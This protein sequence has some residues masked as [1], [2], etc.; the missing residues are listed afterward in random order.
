MQ[1]PIQPTKNEK[2]DI[3][4]NLLKQIQDLWP[5]PRSICGP[6][7]RKSIEYFAS[8]HDQIQVCE[9]KTGT[10]LGGGWIVPDEWSL[11]HCFIKDENENIL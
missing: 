2:I 6:G 3:N 1:K 7:L 5:I 11:D 9:I 4:N 8:I 10:D